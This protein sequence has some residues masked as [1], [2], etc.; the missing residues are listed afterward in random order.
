MPFAT[1]LFLCAA[2]LTAASQDGF[3]TVI[4][5]QSGEQMFRG[6]PLG[7]REIDKDNGFIASL[8]VSDDGKS[9]LIGTVS[10]SAYLV[11][12]SINEDKQSEQWKLQSK[13]QLTKKGP[14]VIAGF[15]GDSNVFA[16]ASEKFGGI[17][18]IDPSIGM[19]PIQRIPVQDFVIDGLYHWRDMPI[20]SDYFS[21]QPE[22]KS[23]TMYTYSDWEQEIDTESDPVSKLTIDNSRSNLHA[24][25]FNG[26]YSLGTGP[27]VVPSISLHD[28]QLL[29]NRS[30]LKSPGEGNYAFVLREFRPN[31]L[32]PAGAMAVTNDDRMVWMATRDGE[33]VA[34]SLEFLSRDLRNMACDSL[35]VFPENQFS[36]FTRKIGIEAPCSN[37]RQ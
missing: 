20:Y 35:P 24:S 28:D 32:E 11:K 26:T 1:E 33:L 15:L 25:F 27:T 7:E 21:F 17:Q 31:G 22:T 9:L 30:G 2:Y 3:V 29:V 6:F 10:G 8:S 23:L 5:V 12:L 13:Y 19:T 18:I 36:E 16:L 34:Y 37:N 14:L 4:D